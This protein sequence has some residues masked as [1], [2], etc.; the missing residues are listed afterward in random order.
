MLAD[1]LLIV[2][3]VGRV[4][5]VSEVG[6]V[7]KCSQ[8]QSHTQIGS[9]LADAY[10]YAFS[11]YSLSGRADAY[12]CVFSLFSF[13]P[14][15]FLSPPSLTS[16]SVLSQEGYPYWSSASTGERC[17]PG[18]CVCVCSRLLSCI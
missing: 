4:W 3:K 18:V 14:L 1:V 7:S 16:R 15:S 12:A 10:A 5:S 11:L 6:A 17:A 13:S 8:L 2:W 9:D